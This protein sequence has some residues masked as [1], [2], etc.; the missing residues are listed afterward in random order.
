V[1]TLKKLILAMIVVF[2]FAATSFG[3]GTNEVWMTLPRTNCINGT[4]CMTVGVYVPLTY[5][6]AVVEFWMSSKLTN[7]NGWFLVPG[8]KVVGPVVRTTNT[9]L[10]IE[11]NYNTAGLIGGKFFKVKLY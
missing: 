6:N 8:S 11:V 7:T 1:S 2:G 5:T 4:N 10:Y 9:T 3:Y